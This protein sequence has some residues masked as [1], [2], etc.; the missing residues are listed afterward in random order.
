MQPCRTGVLEPPVVLQRQIAKLVRIFAL[1]ELLQK[2]QDV[3]GDGGLLLPH[4]E[5]T[6]VVELVRQTVRVLPPQRLLRENIEGD[7]VKD[8]CQEPLHIVQKKLFVLLPIIANRMDSAPL[9]QNGQLATI[10]LPLLFMAVRTDHLD[11]LD[12]NPAEAHS[13]QRFDLGQHVMANAGAAAALNPNPSL[14]HVEE[15]PPVR[16]ELPLGLGCDDAAVLPPAMLHGQRV[17]L[18]VKLSG[19]APRHAREGNEHSCI[20]FQRQAAAQ[21]RVDLICCRAV[22]FQHGG[23]E[24]RILITALVGDDRK[25]KLRSMHEIQHRALKLRRANVGRPDVV[26]VHV[27]Q[28]PVRDILLA[29]SVERDDLAQDGGQSLW[30]EHDREAPRGQLSLLR[31]HRHH[32]TPSVEEQ[33][34]RPFVV[35][36]GF[37][38]NAR[39]VGASQEEDVVHRHHVLQLRA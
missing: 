22:G 11:V 34:S 30:L 36:T 31:R 35:D 32:D 26:Q 16:I 38:G 19:E 5:P 29:V 15:D 17:K 7:V 8:T 24:R 28:D 27:L 23:D 18:D 1:G 13:T 39:P 4:E 9:G 10:Q 20:L 21:I 37:L 33:Q 14:G 6:R 3:G 12:G 25:A 2:V